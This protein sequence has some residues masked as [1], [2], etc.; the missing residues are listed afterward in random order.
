MKPVIQA[1]F[2]D[3]L[4]IQPDSWSI[5]NQLYWSETPALERLMVVSLNLAAVT[6]T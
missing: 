3:P 5:F 1:V 6:M 2:C 4:V